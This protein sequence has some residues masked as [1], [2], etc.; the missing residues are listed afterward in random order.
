MR[1]SAGRAVDGDL[2]EAG[3]ELPQRLIVCADGL[4]PRVKLVIG[5]LQGKLRCG[6][7]DLSGASRQLPL[8]RGAKG[9]HASKA[10]LYEGKV[11]RQS[12]DG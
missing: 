11:A 4:Q 9:R 3:E 6:A 7:I 2:G 5:Q 8:R 10:F 12:R 1:D